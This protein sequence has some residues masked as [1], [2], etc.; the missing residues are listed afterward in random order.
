M[1]REPRRIVTGHDAEGKSV[2]V[3]DG[4]PT[5]FGA[6]CW[7]TDAT[8]VNNTGSGDAGL[9]VR[10]LEPPPSGS[11]FRFA[12]IPPEDPK[13]SREER[14]RQTAKLFAQMDAAHC[15]SD[16]SRHPGMH[17]TRTIDY[18]VL[19]SGEV[20]LLLDKGEVDLK[21]FDVVVQCGT[22]HAWVNNGKEPALI[23]AV[24]IDAKAWH[25]KRPRRPNATAG[26][27]SKR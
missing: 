8:P 4:P 19:L 20:T 14:E 16:T 22:S 15:R 6:Y 24:R 10:K 7:M 27:A 21:P 25:E 2:F 3:I 11:I 13:V 9:Q 17:K 12:A 18:V 1:A 5:P 23:A 26:L